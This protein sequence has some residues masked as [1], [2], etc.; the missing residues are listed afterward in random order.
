MNLIYAVVRIGPAISKHWRHCYLPSHSL[1]LSSLFVTGEEYPKL[2][3]RWA[4]DVPNLTTAKNVI[5][6]V[7][8]CS[9]DPSLAVQSPLQI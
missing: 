5:F 8:F 7:H 2:V 6:F 3:S 4:E 1:S 9:K